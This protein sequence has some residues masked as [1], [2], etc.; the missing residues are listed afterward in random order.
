MDDE[1]PPLEDRRDPVAVRLLA[2]KPARPHGNERR[3]GLARALAAV[4][5]GPGAPG[6]EEDPSGSRSRS[7]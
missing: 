1:D 7:P 6:E 3:R 4:L 5:A 2:C